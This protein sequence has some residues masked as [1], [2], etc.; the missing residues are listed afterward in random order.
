MSRFLIICALLLAGPARALTP[1]DTPT[2]VADIAPVH[3]LVAAVMG[4]LGAPDLLLPPDDDPHGYQ[5]R[6]SQARALA[7]A[8]LVIW[9]GPALTPWMDRMLRNLDATHLDLLAADAIDPHGWL[10][11]VQAETYLTR[12]AA[13]LAALDPANAGTY[14]QNAALAVARLTDLRQTLRT[15]LADN[16]ADLIPSH[17]AYGGFFAAFDLHSDA[18]ISDHQAHQPGAAHLHDISEHLH[19]ADHAC[20]LAEPGQEPAIRKTLQ[21]DAHVAIVTVDPIGAAIPLGPD[22]YFALLQSIA[23]AIS[24]CE[25][26]H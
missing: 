9:I 5:L 18:A 3:G 20:I 10:D 21:P 17:D 15:Q 7:S 1:A 19:D 22:H 25:T 12:I 11:P 2:I 16:D 14:Q 23:D 4:D 26:S 13:E 6:P 8:D 24:S